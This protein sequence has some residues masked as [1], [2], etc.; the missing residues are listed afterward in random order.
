[1]DKKIIVAA[2]VAILVIAG[3]GIYAITSDSKEKDSSYTLLAVANSEGSGLYIK[4][5]IFN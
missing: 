4:D 1:M 5:N 2:I 3:I